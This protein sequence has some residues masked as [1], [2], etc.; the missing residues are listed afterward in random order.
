MAYPLTGSQ[1]T[2]TSGTVIRMSTVTD[3]STSATRILLPLSQ[4]GNLFIAVRAGAVS[5]NQP[6]QAPATGQMWPRGNPARSG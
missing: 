5:V 6:A 3:V 1:Q 4:V 2:A